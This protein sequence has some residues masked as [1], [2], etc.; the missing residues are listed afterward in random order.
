[1]ARPRRRSPEIERLRSEIDDVDR[2]LLALLSRRGRLAESIGRAKARRG[3]ALHAP[4]RER[5]VL[6]RMVS[7]NPGPFPD[8]AIEA[9][10]REVMSASLALEG[11]LTIAVADEA[12]RAAARRRFG[13]AARLRSEIGGPEAIEAVARGWA[14]YG[15]LAVE[16]SRHGFLGPALDAIA[17]GHIPVTG[18]I[19]LRADGATVRALVVGGDPPAP[20]GDDQTS[21]V[22]VPRD[23][24]GAVAKLLA[25]FGRRGV[26]LRRIEARPLKAGLS[27]SLARWRYQFF[28]DLEG[29]R[30]DPPLARAL[31]ELSAGGA[32]VRVLGSYP[33][34]RMRD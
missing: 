23:E 17:D 32:L 20:T 14:A 12:G 34:G 3:L 31:T 16:D 10:F 9:V 21:C 2:K 30:A 15:V 22:L 28:A 5:E 11:P 29:H 6:A 1:M 18:E 4:A 33:R 24:P 8:E 13:A 19:L 26:N 27:S 25:A 7:A